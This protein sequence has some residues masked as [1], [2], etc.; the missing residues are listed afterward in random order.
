MHKN[1]PAGRAVHQHS[2][3]NMHLVPIEPQASTSAELQT[4]QY[5]MGIQIAASRNGMIHGPETIKLYG[6]SSGSGPGLSFD[7]I[8]AMN[9]SV[10]PL[11]RAFHGATDFAERAT[12]EWPG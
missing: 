2:Y 3:A 5:A 4:R 1:Q 11:W 8:P 9:T 12:T 6:R 7:Q 10:E